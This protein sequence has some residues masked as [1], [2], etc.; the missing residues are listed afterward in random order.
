MAKRNSDN[1]PL[2]SSLATLIVNMSID[3]N[4]RPTYMNM[5]YLSELMLFSLGMI[6]KDKDPLNLLKYLAAIGT[7]IVSSPLTSKPIAI[8][9][10][11]NY[12]CPVN[13]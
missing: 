12:I 8:F 2:W 10:L 9:P 11:S 6:N 13:D 4:Q 3:A 1:Q 7:Q 5:E